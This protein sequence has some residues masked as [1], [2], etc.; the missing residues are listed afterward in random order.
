MKLGHDGPSLINTI[1][2]CPC[3][4]RRPCGKGATPTDGRMTN[5]RVTIGLPVYNGERYLEEALKAL[6]VQDMPDFDL[7][8][9]DN[10]STDSTPRILEAYA[11]REPRMR[12][13]RQPQ[14]I[15]AS[16]NF[17]VVLDEARA[18]YF[19][20]AGHDDIYAPSYLRKTLA[21]L[22]ANPSAVLAVS[23]IRFIDGEGKERPEWKGFPNLHTVGLDRVER[24]RQM[25]VRT[26]WYAIYGLSRPEHLRMAGMDRPVFGPDVH[27]LMRL[28]LIGDIARV[29]EPLF[30]YRIERVKKPEDYK[31]F[32]LGG[33][34]QAAYTGLFLALIQ[35]V[36]ESAWSQEEKEAVIETGV[37]TLATENLIWRGMIA[38][39]SFGG[40]GIIGPRLFAARLTWLVGCALPGGTSI[41]T[42]LRRMARVLWRI[43]L[44]QRKQDD[45][46]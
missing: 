44:P 12:V 26:G 5:P 30:E 38:D 29:D 13:I 23:Q 40:A 8:V 2:I 33:Q 24:L 18:P 37:H 46:K 35:I 3:G 25:F 16:R 6:L 39:E 10:A 45:I 32:V 42:E 1:G 34:M 43:G 36:F 9:S 7:V 22:E 15:G 20:W 27:A 31:E 21:A 28:L 19:L 41:G 11:A 4:N 14:N 17:A